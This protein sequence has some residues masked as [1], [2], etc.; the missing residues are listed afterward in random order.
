MDYIKHKHQATFSV[1]RE[2]T[3]REKDQHSLHTSHTS[4]N[5]MFP[6]M[7][8]LSVTLTSTEI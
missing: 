3:N 5:L 7:N 8:N 1:Y 4:L 6:V 2:I